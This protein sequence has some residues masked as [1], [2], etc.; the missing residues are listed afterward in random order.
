MDSA[1]GI[2]L[3]E[4]HAHLAVVRLYCPRGLGDARSPVRHILGLSCWRPSQ[5]DAIELLKS[6]A[7]IQ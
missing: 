2:L 4:A 5:P 6:I 7:W 3:R 1:V